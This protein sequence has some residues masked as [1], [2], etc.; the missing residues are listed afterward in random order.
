M[1]GGVGRTILLVEDEAI[2]AMATKAMLERHGFAVIVA[3]SG[4]A[5]LRAAA[6]TPGLDLALMDINLGDGMDGT[7]AATRMLAERDLPLVFLSS[8]TEREVVERTE[9][10]TSYGYI[11]KNSGE[12]VLMAA[13]GMAFK[14]HEAKLREAEKSRALAESE[15]KY[16]SLIEN[17][18]DI[19]YTLDR[20]GVF[21]FVSP[22]WT[23]LLGHAESEAIGTS[24]ERFVHPD[25]LP[26]CREWL[27]QVVETG[28]RESGIEYRV[29]HADGTWRWHSSSASPA[30]DRSGA[31]TGFEGI[32]RDI[33]ETKAIKD[34]LALESSILEAVFDSVPGLLY[35]YDE[36][37]RLRRWNRRHETMT[38]YGPDELAGMR[39]MDWYPGDEASQR[40]VLEG[41]ERTMRDGFGEAEATLRR[42]DGS[43]VPMYFTASSIE[44]H[45]ERFFA[46]IGLDLGERKRAERALAAGERNLRSVFDAI[47]QGVALLERDG[48][49]VA[50]NRVFAERL[51]TSVDE[52]VGAN[53]FALVPPDVAAS[54]RLVMERVIATGM[55]ESLEDARL[56]IRLHNRVCPV[57]GENGTTARVV[58]YAADVTEQRKT[59]ESLRVSETLYR[60]L[61]DV[62]PVGITISDEAGRILKSNRIAEGILGL[63]AD[64]H[65]GRAIDGSE[66]RVLRPDGSPMPADEYASTRALR[67]GALV[68]NVEMGVERGDGGVSW[69]NVSAAPV[70]LEG[71]GVVIAYVDITG[72]RA[73]ERRIADLLKEK[74]LLLRETHHRIKNNIGTVIG[75]LSLQAG[76]TASEEAR[77]AL[78]AAAGRLESMMVLYDR[79]YRSESFG[80]LDAGDFLSTLLPQLAQAIGCDC[81]VELRMD[82]V[83]FTLA[84]RQL[85]PL[86]IILYELLN[87]SAKHAFRPG[88]RGR[89]RVTVS[90]TGGRVAVEYADD[91]P[92]LPAPGSAAGAPGFGMQLVVA[93]AEQLGGSFRIGDGPGARFVVEFPE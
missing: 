8:H 93:L 88:V 18:H 70:P 89:V 44:I 11:V 13:L 42:K 78:E 61:F 32:G 64:R 90:R 12:T 31:V 77:D 33:T 10:I 76:G 62:V 47:D 20:D 6:S 85:S 3:P 39:L 73:A 84:A 58:I 37:G 68:G 43:L 1:S 83:G 35:L 57:A 23:A 15:A 19:I 59:M 38:G 71:Y 54:R 4:E 5:A 74:E 24:F 55:P 22:A 16:R 50:C 66:W 81:S 14:L 30:R 17:S 53:A 67:E 27:R 7:E 2:I 46:G 9:G 52:C 65:E 34:T 82:S 87:N 60:T 63:P 41:V 40:A 29:R 21:T 69:I 86:G 45:G 36:E 92:G 72:H 48:T 75:L 56:G 26:A 79:L 80:A 51:G 49:I 28:S 91:G 25:D